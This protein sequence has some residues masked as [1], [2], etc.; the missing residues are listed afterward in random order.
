MR[1]STLLEI[2]GHDIAQLGDADLRTITGLLCEADF[3]HA[4]LPVIGITWGGHQDAPDGGLDVVVHSECD[5]PATSFLKRRNTGIQVK[6]P[7]MQPAKITKEMRPGGILREDIKDLINKGGAYVIINSTGS[8]SGSALKARVNAMKSAI[9]DEPGHENLHLDYLDQGRIATWVRNHPSLALWV[10]QKIGR[11]LKG[12]HPYENWS[13]APGGLEEEYL[14]DEGLRLTDRT[15]SN[16][17][18]VSAES[19]LLKLRELL[20]APGRCVRLAGLSGV[21]KTR[22]VQALFDSRIGDQALNTHEAIYTDISE[23]PVPDA[24]GMLD[25]LLAAETRAILIIDNCPPELHSQLARKCSS[26]TSTVSL[27]TVEYDV[28]DDLPDETDVFRLSPA[29]K[30]LIETLLG[31]RFQHVTQVDTKTIAEFSGGNAR[32]AI[33]LAK[34]VQKGETLSSFREEELFERL[35]WQRHAENNELLTAAEV[36]SLVYSFEGTDTS[37]DAS[38][39]KFLSALIQNTPSELYK[40]VD[41]LQQRDLIQS[42]GVWRAVLPHAVANR[43]ARRALKSIPP[44]ILVPF[45]INQGTER[46]IKSFSRRLSYLHDC[47]TAIDIV[48][49]WLDPEGWLGKS[50]GNF[51]D[52]GMDVFRNIAPI[53]PEK[54][55][56]AIE[57]ASVLNEQLFSEENR[58]FE[59]YIGLLRKLSY[60]PEL[61]QK[62]VHL[63]LRFAFIENARIKNNAPDQLKSLFYAY[64]SGTKAPAKMRAQVIEELLQSGNPK[65]QW[66]GCECLSAALESWH[67]SSSYDFEFGARPRD[68][69]YEPETEEEF[70][71][72]YETFIDI[73]IRYSHEASSIS[74]KVRQELGNKLRGLWLKVGNYDFL[75]DAAR[76]IHSERPWR[77]GWIAIKSIIG[78]DKKQ[79]PPEVLSRIYALEEFL[80]PNNLLDKARIFAFSDKAIDIEGVYWD[81]ENP[82]SGLEKAYAITRELGKQVAQSPSVFEKILSEIVSTSGQRILTFGEG[83]AEGASNPN[84]IWTQLKNQFFNT[85]P[86]RREIR[87][88]LDLFGFVPQQ[89]LISI[90]LQWT[91]WLKTIS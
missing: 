31:K 32:L 7:D 62:S 9:A 24:G 72:W 59:G 54:I 80:R 77:E 50:I 90:N 38:E 36:L 60:E 49:D 52:F 25:Q 70:F 47:D 68:Y 56:K 64:L 88:L 91:L 66:L 83:L 69:G 63:M 45:F 3:R 12:W 43:L 46:L 4:K 22:F 2:T 67:F 71:L 44:D 1:A 13:K 73:C 40:H 84:E 55:L 19:G 61:F 42:R 33:A 10:H 87:A 76:K 39:L 74:N 85:D 81:D 26:P 41:A 57:S 17:D 20:S 58:H 11:P 29:S 53:A 51:N 18:G 30:E 23:G 78:F 5:P 21:G 65:E 48:T 86:E 15:T 89:S 14:L 16:N 37:S 79:Y 8:T 28:R 27:L 75:E 34:T 6:K 82:V 35:F